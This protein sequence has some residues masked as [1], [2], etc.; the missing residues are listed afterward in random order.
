MI[1]EDTAPAPA[2]PVSRLSHLACLGIGAGF[3][4]LALLPWLVTGMHLP[5]QNLWAVETRPEDMPIAL[6]PLNQYLVVEIL[7][8]LVLAYGVGGITLRVI[9]RRRPRRAA[10]AVGGGVLGVHLVAAVQAVMTVA[11]G[12]TE[13]TA[14]TLY[15]AALVGVV[16]MALLTGLGVLWLVSAPPR[17]GAVIGLSIAALLVMPWLSALLVPLGT[18]PGGLMTSV[19]VTLLPWLP[20]TL[21]G[22]TIGWGGLGTRARVVAAVAALTL[23]WLVP[24]ALTA[25]TAA[26]GSRVLLPYP[27]EMVDYGLGVFRAAA[28]APDLV[29][30]RLLVA[31]AVA[32]AG[33]AAQRLITRRTGPGRNRAAAPP[34]RPAPARR[35][36]P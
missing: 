15:V 7:S 12:L 11:A 5:L 36:L 4:L 33:I 25:V 16:G 20:A 9:G 22:A 8:L 30:P 32:A 23:L 10:L 17:A 26:V 31:L 13:R 27:T 35:E 24:A 14:S 21:V 28:S 18:P 1:T 2:P 19:L 6:L 3:A 34:D 29:V